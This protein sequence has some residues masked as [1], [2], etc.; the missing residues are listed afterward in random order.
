MLTNFMGSSNISDFFFKNVSYIELY[1][2]SI[3]GVVCVLFLGV[4]YTHYAH[5]TQH[6]KHTTQTPTHTTHTTHNTTNTLHAHV[7][8]L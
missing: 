3:I 7:S 1:M 4:Y 8:Q 5:H 2:G 6:Y